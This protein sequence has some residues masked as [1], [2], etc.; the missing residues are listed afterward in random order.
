MSVSGSTNKLEIQ[1]HLGRTLKEIYGGLELVFFTWS[2]E[3]IADILLIRTKS[4][5]SL[6]IQYYFVWVC[7]YF[8][9]NTLCLRIK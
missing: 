7:T 3:I 5:N 8:T 9:I 4:S 6:R 2:C 1:R